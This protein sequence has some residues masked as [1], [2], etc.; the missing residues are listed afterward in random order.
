MANRVTNEQLEAL[1]EFLAGHRALLKSVGS[2]R[3]WNA[4]AL[5]LNAF[6]SGSTKTGE[7]WKKVTRVNFY[8]FK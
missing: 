2:V 8:D 3:Q 6:D 7:Q 5:K 1:V 4:L